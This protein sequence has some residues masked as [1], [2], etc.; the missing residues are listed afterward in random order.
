MALTAGVNVTLSGQHTSALDF[1]TASF[2]LAKKMVTSFANGSGLNQANKIFTDTRAVLTAATDALDLNGGGLT[3]AFGVALVFSAL[4]GLIIRS[5]AA[6][7][8][9]LTILGNAAA[10]PILGTVATTMALKPGGVFVWLDTSA[11]GTTVT[12]GT[13]DIIQVVNAAGA[14]ANF[15]IVLLGI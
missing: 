3:D 11:A 1:N 14:T 5:A 15:D 6:N 2:D 12:A 8:T 10:V 7:T 4:K 9:V 13:G